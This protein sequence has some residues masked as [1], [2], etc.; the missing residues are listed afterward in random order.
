VPFQSFVF[1][2]G[3]L[4]VIEVIGWPCDCPAGERERREQG[5]KETKIVKI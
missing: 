5:N 1:E 3:L 2:Q 4:L